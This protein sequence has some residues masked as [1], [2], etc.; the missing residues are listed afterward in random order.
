MNNKYI[1]ASI[2]TFIVLVFTYN[3]LMYVRDNYYFGKRDSNV[4]VNDYE[5]YFNL[6]NAIDSY[7]NN[8][9]LEDCYTNMKTATIG[10]AVI[11]K[12][13]IDR[14]KDIYE[15]DKYEYELEL[16]DMKYLE[17]DTYKCKYT[18]SYEAEIGGVGEEINV[19]KDFKP[20]VIYENE[21]ILKI[22]RE[23]NAYKVISNKI[24]LGGGN[25]YE[26]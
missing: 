21:I 10:S 16:T 20:S 23:M 19:D 17:K 8:L 2:I 26:K 4:D 12:N 7:I 18:F 15:V 14:I 22:N 11:L 1:K 3:I 6:Y 5:T 25:F 9:A 13:D 24:D